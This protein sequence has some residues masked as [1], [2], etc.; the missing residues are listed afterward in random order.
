MHLKAFLF[1]PVIYVSADV[2]FIFFYKSCEWEWLKICDHQD[3]S[4]ARTILHLIKNRIDK[5][6]GIL[7]LVR[8]RICCGKWE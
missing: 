7:L 6:Q 3:I 5:H 8:F 4:D 2:F 1:W